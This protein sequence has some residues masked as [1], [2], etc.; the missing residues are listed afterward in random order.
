MTD[1]LRRLLRLLQWKLIY[2]GAK[3]DITLDTWNGLLTCNTKN[4]L[5]GKYLYVN[6]SYEADNI[7]KTMDLLRREGYLAGGGNVVFDVGANIGMIAIALLKR[8][9]FQSAVAFEPEPDNFRLLLRNVTQNSLENRITC[10]PYALSS[11]VYAG[12][13]TLELSRD[14]FGDHRIRHSGTAGFFNE[15]KRQVMPVEMKTLDGFLENYKDIDPN[16]VSLI[17]ID[18]QGHEGHFFEGAH[19]LL[20]RRIPVVSEFWPYAIERSGMPLSRYREILVENFTHFYRFKDD[21]FE[22]IPISQVDELFKLYNTPRSGDQLVL[23]R[24]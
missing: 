13:G 16:A 14:N 24:E 6:R 9:Y 7:E 3:R 21:G 17:W 1:R 11:H 8:K 5:I 23:V 2:Y 12:Q 19:E 18:I 10:L 4:W 22:K 15:E 20:K